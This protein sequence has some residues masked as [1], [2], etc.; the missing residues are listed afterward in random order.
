[1]EYGEAVFESIIGFS[2]KLRKEVI[3]SESVFIDFAMRQKNEVAEKF[4]AKVADEI[5]SINTQD[6]DVSIGIPHPEEI[7]GDQLRRYL[8]GRERKDYK[9]ENNVT[10]DYWTAEFWVILYPKRGYSLAWKWRLEVKD[11]VL[12]LVE[13]T[14]PEILWKL[15]TI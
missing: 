12:N 5:I 8:D 3:L 10:L 7:A 14:E 9:T 4:R 11:T 13:N 6:R 15:R 1:M 2:R